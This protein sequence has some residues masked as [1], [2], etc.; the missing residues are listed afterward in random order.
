MVKKVTYVD[1]FS[2][3]FADP[4]ARFSH[5]FRLKRGKTLTLKTCLLFRLKIIKK[6]V[7]L[8]RTRRIITA[9]DK[10]NVIF[11][12][13]GSLSD[14]SQKK[15]GPCAVARE[16]NISPSTVCWI[17]DRFHMVKQDLDR[18]VIRGHPPGKSR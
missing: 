5:E 12:S 2:D 7:K 8:F 9:R 6:M 18:F 17:L 1:P 10:L 16:C 11:S 3:P 14:F 4:F 15:C 13:Y